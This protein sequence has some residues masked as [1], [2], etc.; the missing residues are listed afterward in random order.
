MIPASF[1]YF[2]PR[3]VPEA[4]HLLA[5]YGPEAK[6]LAGGHSLVPLM[7]LRLAAPRYII[8]LNRIDGLSYIRE[9][10]GVLRLGALTR[11]AEIEHSELIRARYP[12]LADAARV[13]S[14]PL[15]RNMG[16]IGGSLAHADPAGDW[17]AAMLAAGAEVVAVGPG[18]TRTIPIDGFF[19]GTFVTALRPDEVLTEIRLPRA[20]KDAGGA[21]L[22]L[23]RKVGDFA[24]AAVGVGLLLDGGGTCQ[25]VGIGLCNVGPISLRAAQASRLLSGR[26][27]EESVLAR[28]AEA[29]AAECDP[30]D[31]LRGP[32]DYKRDMVRVLTLRALRLAVQ[33]ARG[34]A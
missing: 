26:K 20:A 28:A 15:V 32:A 6:L 13:I 11:H 4:V 25:Q 21:Y 9:E 7:K 5:R 8:D 14:D 10:D 29:A 3:T 12:L 18:G 33:R 22:K 1:E 19:E 24:I 16:T 31:D 34:G 17:G 23:E 2:S 30:A 27:P